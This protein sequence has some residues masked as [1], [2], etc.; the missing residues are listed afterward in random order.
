MLK[1]IVFY[2]ANFP[3]DSILP[4][5][6]FFKKLPTDFQ[7][8]DAEELTNALQDE[9]VTAFVHLHGPYFPKEAW[10]AILQYLETGKGF[11]HLGGMPFRIPCFLAEG[12]WQEETA[13]TAYHQQ[14]LIHEILTVKQDP[15]KSFQHNEEIPL[16]SQAEDLFSN[17]IDTYNFI[18]HVTR[19]S[20][21]EEEMGSV[22]PMD[23]RI[24]P[25][26]KG[27][28]ENGRQRSAPSV[29]LEHTKGS[30]MGG[31]W[32]FINQIIQESFWTEKGADLLKNF[33]SF[34]Q[35]GV[36][37]MWLK[38]N[39]ASFEEGERPQVSYQFQAIG[40]P[41]RWELSFQVTKESEVVYT[42]TQSIK[43][44]KDIQ[45]GSF[46]LP[47]DIEA[48]FYE[49]TCEAVSDRGE[50]RILTQGF[51]GR[52]QKLLE[53]GE[54]LTCT[55]H[56]FE[57]EGK[58]FP[59]VGMTYMT[60][61]V[62]RY[63]LFLPNPKAWDRD[64]AQ[65]KRAGINYIRTG[66]WTA[67]R[68]MMFVDGHMEENILR[69]IDAFILC[70]KRHDIHV[71]FT[72]F[73]FTPETWD[74]EN[75]YL[76][77]RSV[78]A[79]KRFI[80]VI[81]SRHQK[82]KN[83][84]WDL[85]NEPSV[86]D[87][88]HTFSGPRTLKDAHDI[89][90]FQAWLKER[91]P[92]IE[93]LQERWNMTAQEIPSFASIQPPHPS[94]INL[95]TRNMLEAK[96]GLHWY[97]YTLYTMDMHNKWAQELKDTIK[98]I[99]PDHLVTV[100]QDEALAAQ[101]PSPFFYSEVADYTSNHSWWLL[102]DLL[103]DGIFTKTP[104]KPN[105]IQETGIMYVEDPNNQARRT[106]EELRNI[107]ERKYAYAFSTGGAGAVQWL[108]N[109]NYF[110][111]NVNES[112]IGALRA[113]GT[114]KP[115]TNVSYDFGEFMGGIHD[116]FTDRELEEVGVIFPYANDFSNQKLAYTATTN[117]TRV[118]A[119][120]LN[121]PFRAFGEYH[122]E[123]LEDESPKLLLVPSPH[124]F[125][126]QAFRHLLKIVEKQGSTLL[127]T[128][129]V[130]IDE[131]YRTTDRAE[132]IVGE[133]TNINIVREE[134]LQINDKKVF[135]SFPGDRIADTR[136]GQTKEGDTA[137][138]VVTLGKGKVIWSPLPIELNSEKEAMIELYNYALETAEVSK[139]LR[140]KQGDYPGVYGRKLDF[141][142]GKL[143]IFVSEFGED[144][145]VEITDPK[146]NK[147]YDFTLEKE[148][149]VMFATDKDGKIRQ[150]YRP[151]EVTIHE[152]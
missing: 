18:L 108:W 119:Y 29:L 34:V 102:D 35:N 17:K 147:T 74:G 3:N 143:F 20:S 146:T 36:T 104:D 109:T 7:V 149:T 66:V 105:V 52:D 55:K 63:F 59:I 15:I 54:P 131:Y 76:D 95:G 2:D 43:A 114:E 45:F 123:A 133:T 151:H 94:E 135:A 112:N 150:V 127:F 118:L 91:H 47:I 122:L 107:L 21:I 53:D 142:D 126:D 130:N 83:V 141:S 88:A 4:E 26:V 85:I 19:K 145:P 70:A 57:K 72:F 80:R 65:M 97:D 22:G 115:E 61:D 82:T 144:C 148:R 11:V 138:Q 77:P 136:K 110:M 44:D 5:E 86:F 64:M 100:G 92:S 28:S 84:D 99:V 58:P 87:P 116:L 13:Q 79:Q 68:Q 48:G 139:H 124:Q 90:H 125:T 98:E 71:T 14:L 134:L 23:A 129:P 51:W 56:Y 9:E 117:L 75:P 120:D 27:I 67:W 132:K 24:Y 12:Q 103:W 41:A 101:R 42:S 39:Y 40:K 69:S 31:R 81:V 37:E 1:T 6:D 46:V 73:S 10:P 137:V 62:A 89:E 113:D 128:G 140:W 33:I 8:V 30:F 121:V 93:V 25:L 78:E 38:T 106:E 49:L 16:F 96:K 60:S 50:K 111:N 32:I 152:K